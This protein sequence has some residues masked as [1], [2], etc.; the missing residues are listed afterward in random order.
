MPAGFFGQPVKKHSLSP[1][2][3]R[4]VEM[5]QD[6]NFGRLEG[7]H[8]RKG[9]PVF[10]PPPR[11][12][13][14]IKFGGANGPRREPSLPDCLLKA[15]VLELFQSLDQL[16]DGTIEVLDVKHGLPFRMLVAEAVA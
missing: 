15:Q 3:R 6:L 11:A 14:E 10:D 2:R 8:I 16:R 12:I 1:A 9:D 5:C 7:L 13:R 4:L